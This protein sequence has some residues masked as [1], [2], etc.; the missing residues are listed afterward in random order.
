MATTKKALSREFKILLLTILQ[1]NSIEPEQR[2]AAESYFNSYFGFSIPFELRPFSNEEINELIELNT[3]ER[4]K[5][6]ATHKDDPI[7]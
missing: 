4:E 1:N 3:K 2:E 7:Y 5:W 6:N